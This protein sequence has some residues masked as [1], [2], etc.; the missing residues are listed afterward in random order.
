MP[1][2]QPSDPITPNPRNATN[3]ATAATAIADVSL[4]ALSGTGSFAVEQRFADIS[5]NEQ[6]AT[7]YIDATGA[8]QIKIP[9]AYFND[10]L[11]YQSAT[12][13]YAVDSVTI[14]AEYLD[15][16]AHTAV[17]SVGRLSTLNSDFAA[18]VNTYFGVTGGFESLY[19]EESFA[20]TKAAEV[21]GPEQFVA[22]I[23]G[24]VAVNAT[25]NAETSA[26]SGTVTVSN[27]S[28]LL[29][30]AVDGNVFANRTPG[31]AVGETTDWGLKNKFVAGDL[32][33]CPSGIAITLKLGLNPENM[34]PINALSMTLV[35]GGSGNFTTTAVGTTSLLTRVAN[36][37]ILFILVA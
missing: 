6:S 10:Q 34:L 4:N 17:L 25:T 23:D 32:I 13:D 33:W 24:A 18:F 2:P 9:V 21:F 36:A 28:Q 29:R 31:G 37:P 5:L 20:S 12:D 35:N 30:Y 11:T 19:A 14:S 7:V 22:L 27:V 16:I 15:G 3:H 26:L 1:I 8:V